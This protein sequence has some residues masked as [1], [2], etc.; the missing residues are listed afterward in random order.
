[1]YEMRVLV[2][3]NA[4]F[5]VEVKIFEAIIDFPVPWAVEGSQWFWKPGRFFEQYMPCSYGQF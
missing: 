1:M 3:E 2:Y 5:G 4:Y